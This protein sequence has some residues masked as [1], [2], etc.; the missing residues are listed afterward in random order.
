MEIKRI[1][2]SI[3]LFVNKKKKEKKHINFYLRD[4]GIA[5]GWSV[6]WLVG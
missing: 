5:I 3:H 6:G 4:V 2:N 1:I